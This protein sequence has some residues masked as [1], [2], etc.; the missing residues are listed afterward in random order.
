MDK[1]RVLRRAQPAVAARA[2]GKRGLPRELGRCLRD[3]LKVRQ[4]RSARFLPPRRLQE[5]AEAEPA[6]APLPRAGGGRRGRRGFCSRA[7]GGSF[8]REGNGIGVSPRGEGAVS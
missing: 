6:S 4:S 1:D 2:L 3:L 7:L 5:G 8:A